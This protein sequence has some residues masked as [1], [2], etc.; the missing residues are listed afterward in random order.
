MKKMISIICFLYLSVLTHAAEPLKY[1]NA[2]EFQ[3]LGRGFQDTELP[4][5]RLPARLKDQVRPEL[6]LFSTHSSGMAIRFRTDS[7]TIGA[8]WEVTDNTV[9]NHMSFTGIKGLDLYCLMDNGKWQSVNTGRPVDKITT[10]TIVSNL[11]GE[12]REYMLYLPLYD[13]VKTLEI[14]VDSNSAI[15]MPQVDTPRKGR[16]VVAYGTS[17][18]QGA[19]ASKPGMSYPNQLSRMLNRE[20]INMGFSANGRLDSEVAEAITEIDNPSCYIIDCVPNCSGKELEER[21]EPFINILRDKHPDV[22]VVMIEGIIYP[23]SYFDTTLSGLTQAKNK[24]LRNVY[25][26]MKAAGV[27]NL[28][29]IPATHLTGDD[30]E[31]S[32]DGIHMTDLGFKRFTETVYPVIRQI[33]EPQEIRAVWI[34]DPNHT[35]ALHTYDNLLK[36]VNLLDSLNFNMIYIC[37]YIRSQTAWKS[38]VLAN[39]STYETP[40]EGYMF[41]PYAANYKSATSDPLQD[42]IT[43]AHK[44]GIKVV[45]WFEQGFM[46]GH[47]KINTKD[48]LVKKNPAWRGIGNDG[49]PVNYNNTDFYFNSYHPAVQQFLLDLIGESLKMYPNVDGIQGDDRLPAA[50]RNSGYDKYTVARYKA[51]FSGINPPLDFN[52]PA[53]VEWRLEILNNFAKTLHQKIKEIKPDALVCFSPNPYPWCETHLMQDW[54]SWL[55]ENIVDVLSVQCYRNTPEAYRSTVMEAAEYVQKNTT[56]HVLNPGMIL[57][58][59]DQYMSEELLRTQLEINRELKTNGESQFYNEGLYNKDAQKVFKDVYSVK[60]TVPKNL[61]RK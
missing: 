3:I 45:F 29:Y 58:I 39:H 46:A 34:P 24:V 32:V 1:V 26:S 4:F 17:I 20:I 14:G 51:E 23:H 21:C 8:R 36:T 37:T 60:A 53:W 40:E 43:E 22:P 10:A 31:T 59:G 57:K 6:W 52:D 61:N 30:F 50:P 35:K 19:C 16:P 15:Q 33:V 55:R 11:K 12:M 9:M 13:G 27:K 5:Q 54:P 44:R 38:Q 28:Y 56:K 42:L 41:R 7:K 48:P 47:G 49:K 25:E 2:L 18:M